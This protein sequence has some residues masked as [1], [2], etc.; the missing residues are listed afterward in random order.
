MAKEAR[1]IVQ[2]GDIGEIRIVIAEFLRSRLGDMIEKEV[3]RQVSSKF[4][5]IMLT[6][7]F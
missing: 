1:E 4:D 6:K 7:C 5:L 3:Q 2:G